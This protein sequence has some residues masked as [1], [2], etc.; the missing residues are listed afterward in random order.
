MTLQLVID[1]VSDAVVVVDSPGTIEMS[2][3]CAARLYGYPDRQ[4]QGKP[5]RVLFP[6]D[7]PAARPIAS[8]LGDARD[9]GCVETQIW[10]RRADATRFLTNLVVRSIPEGEGRGARYVLVTRDLTEQRRASDE[11]SQ[12]DTR[13][14]T[15]VENARDYAIFM[16]DTTGHVASWNEGAQRIKGYSAREIIG[17]HFSKFYM[18]ED[19]RTGKCERELETAMSEGRFEEEGWRLRKDGTRFWANVVIAP[20]RDDRGVHIGFSKITRDLTER[21]AAELDRLS[22]TRTQEALRL[23]DEFLS[24][25]SHELRTPLVALQLQL[26]S[27]DMQAATLQPKQAS[28]ISRARRNATRLADLITT[29]LDVSRIA[30]GRLTLNMREVDLGDLVRE[31]VDRLQESAAAAKNIVVVS[32]ESML[33][34]VCDPLRIGQVLSNLLAN[35]FKYAAG[36]PVDVR[37]GRAGDVAVMTVEDRGPGIS[38]AQ[39]ERIFDRFERAASMRNY[40]GMGLGLY[41]AREIVVAHGGS[42]RAHNR[43][44]G[45]TTV[46]IR[47]PVVSTLKERTP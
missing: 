10:Q 23:R 4:L 16:L 41:V 28:K 21:R 31:V 33:L 9:R 14:R 47:L 19:S 5:I 1:A 17:Q 2:N 11:R 27:L 8:L 3:A 12:E 7:D 25:A 36:T 22:L 39:L 13:F 32:G 30:E 6:D 46:E 42:T 37:L 35:A 26:E 44:G 20:L 29:L 40:P 43:E 18:V 15:L 38:E 34:A 45:G 24:V